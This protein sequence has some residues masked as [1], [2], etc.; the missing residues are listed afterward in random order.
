MFGVLYIQAQDVDGDEV[1][2]GYPAVRC[3]THYGANTPT[4]HGPKKVEIIIGRLQGRQYSPQFLEAGATPT[5]SNQ[6]IP[7]T[8][9]PSPLYYGGATDGN[10]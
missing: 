8:G 1:L 10:S 5:E 2:V 9:T 6:F 3:S 4:N 7:L